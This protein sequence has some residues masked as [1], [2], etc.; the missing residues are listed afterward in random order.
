MIFAILKKGF[1]SK[2][3]SLINLLLVIF[4]VLVKEGRRKANWITEASYPN[5]GK[6]HEKV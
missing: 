4:S 6:K 5:K 1:K 3:V 2:N